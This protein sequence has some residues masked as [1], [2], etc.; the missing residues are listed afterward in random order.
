MLF[1]Q[2]Q[3]RAKVTYRQLR[4]YPPSG[5]QATLRVSLRNPAAEDFLQALLE[6]WRWHGVCQADFIC[7]PD[8]GVPYLIDLNPRLWG[9]LVQAVASGVDF[10]FLIYD[11]ALNGDVPPMT[12]FETGIVTRWLGG[13]VAALFSRLTQPRPKPGNRKGCSQ[14]YGAARLYD[15]FSLA[16]PTP[17]FVWLLDTLGR[18]AKHRSIRAVSHDSL[19]GV[20]E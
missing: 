16:D 6:S 18:A 12:D 9:S 15:D 3:L 14:S 2:G 7:E 4:D 8:S 1:N 19:D 13:E 5:G 20:W 17:F 11:I 10:P